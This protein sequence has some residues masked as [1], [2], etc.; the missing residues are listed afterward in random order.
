MVTQ[1]QKLTVTLTTWTRKGYIGLAWLIVAA[2][3]TQVFLAGMNVFVRPNWL[4]T[5]IQL[6]HTIGGLIALLVVLGFVGRFPGRIRW[7]TVVTLALFAI[8]YNHRRIA[9]LVNL[10]PLAAIHAV[11]ALVLFW[12]ITTVLRWARQ[13]VARQDK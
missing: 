11:N 5:H 10:P 9:G 6:G 7:L 8:Q 13:V 1:Q 12:C 2:I 3:V 4:G